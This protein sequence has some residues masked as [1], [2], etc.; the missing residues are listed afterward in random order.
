M[1]KYKKTISIK[2]VMDKQRQITKNIKLG[3]LFIRK[4]QSN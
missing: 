3:T 2:K 4:A 1:K